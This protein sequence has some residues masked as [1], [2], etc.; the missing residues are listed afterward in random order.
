MNKELLGTLHKTFQ[1]NKEILNTPDVFINE[2]CHSYSGDFPSRDKFMDAL[3][4]RLIL[5]SL[6]IID[7]ADSLEHKLAL[8]DKIYL[9][10]FTRILE[11][12]LGID[13][14][15]AV[16]SVI[17]LLFGIL[18][19]DV[20][21]CRDDNQITIIIGAHDAAKEREVREKSEK[22]GKNKRGRHHTRT[23]NEE[24]RSANKAYRVSDLLTKWIV[25]ITFLA[26]SGVIIY[27]VLSPPDTLL[28]VIYGIAAIGLAGAANFFFKVT[29][30]IVPMFD[31]YV[32]KETDLYIEI[33]CKANGIDHNKT[34]NEE[35]P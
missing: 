12:T 16:F 21:P 23:V 20:D 5:E 27:G 7:D 26:F 24:Y 33:I 10:S 31:K 30:S 4:N 1:K 8:V 15:T 3:K 32:E 28:G 35:R 2:V 6:S 18:G 34:R 11:D 17:P 9:L 25:V 22:S 13:T 14:Q 29:Q 19:I